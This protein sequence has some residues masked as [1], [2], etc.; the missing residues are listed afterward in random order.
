MTFPCTDTSPLIPIGAKSSGHQVLSR[1]AQRSRRD[2]VGALDRFW[3][4]RTL[5]EPGSG[6]RHLF[7]PVLSHPARGFALVSTP[8][9]GLVSPA[10]TRR[11]ATDEH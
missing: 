5:P 3:W 7:R 4:L 1:G 8:R 9:A 10:S 6:N 2:A 11:C